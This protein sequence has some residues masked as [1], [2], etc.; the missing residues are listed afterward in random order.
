M[1]DDV[2]D[3]AIQMQQGNGT[4]RRMNYG[5]NYKEYGIKNDDGNVLEINDDD[6]KA[7]KV[8][9]KRG[10]VRTGRGRGRPRTVNTDKWG[11]REGENNWAK[12]NATN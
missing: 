12:F 8:T 5:E 9:M 11:N 7:E 6:D 4:S 3:D 2:K 1:P 10:N